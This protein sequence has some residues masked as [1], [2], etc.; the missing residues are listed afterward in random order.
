[1]IQKYFLIRLLFTCT[2][3]LPSEK[4]RNKKTKKTTKEKKERKYEYSVW[5]I[6]LCMSLFNSFLENLLWGLLSMK[7][8]VVIQLW[9]CFLLPSSLTI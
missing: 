1:M 6:V 5:R 2:V 7:C 8:A 4:K 3:L 9:K